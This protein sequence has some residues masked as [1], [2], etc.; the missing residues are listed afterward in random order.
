MLPLVAPA[1]QALLFSGIDNR[2]CN[3]ELIA[4]RR[5]KKI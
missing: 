2:R 1:G 3:G 5:K 4:V